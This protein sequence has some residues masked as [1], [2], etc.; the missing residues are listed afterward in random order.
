M[1]LE[2][3]ATTGPP[4]ALLENE[5]QPYAVR[6]NYLGA[7]YVFFLDLHAPRIAQ[8]TETETFLQNLF[9]TKL[10]SPLPFNGW[11]GFMGYDF[12]AAHA[13][14]MTKAPNSLQ[15]P[16][17]VFARPQTIVCYTNSKTEIHSTIKGRSRDLARQATGT[18]DVITA[19]TASKVRCNL[20]FEQY[21]EI[22]QRAR[23]HILDGETYQIKISQRYEAETDISP[24]I[25]FVRLMEINPSP[26]AF[27]WRD[28]DYSLV[29]CSP[30]SVIHLQNN[31]IRTRPIGGTWE[32]HPESEEQVPKENFLKNEK[33]NAEHRMLVDL[34]RNDIGRLCEPGTVKIRQ[35]AKLETY[36][37]L[38]HLVSTIEGKL[39]NDVSGT[40]I[41]RAMLPGGSITGC[42]KYR[43]MQLIDKL[44][45][46]ARSFYTG[47]F[48]TI[49]DDGSLDL[50]L[51][52][53]TML[54]ARNRAWTQ[55]GGGIVADSYPEY[56][57]N[58][59][60]V[61]ARALLQVLEGGA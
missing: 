36:A 33:E 15:L 37:H 56:E 9:E 8:N 49:A 23:E 50:N 54:I 44:E 24:L 5:A 45:P 48:G 11:I 29:S 40:N 57:Y 55:S 21:C 30:E 39:R 4:W 47:S 6:H 18:F 51:M 22:F 10:A 27:L 1:E 41:F 52:I 3:I 19:N 31:I 7:D 25:A 32:R 13:G 61:K 17:A 59:N 58:E 53:R 42:P 28:H 60:A 26:Q 2:I 16:H 43:T 35:L 12:L 14:V 46:C 34:E 20:D 38:Y